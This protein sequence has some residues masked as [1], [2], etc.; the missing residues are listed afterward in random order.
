MKYPDAQQYTTPNQK[1]GRSEP[2]TKIV[3]HITD[4][5]GKL[6][7]A[8]EHFQKKENQLSAHFLIAPDGTVAQLVSIEN[9]AWHCKGLNNS[10]V[11]IETMAR[12]KGELSKTDQGMPMTEAQ[13]KSLS[14]L[15]RWLCS[16]LKMPMDREHII[17]HNEA[18][19]KEGNLLSS[20]KDC[21]TGCLNWDKLMSILK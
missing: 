14:E 21:P 8:I 19:D 13:Y 12:S 7:R 1:I 18:R 11:G 17:G 2:I 6:S 15:I 16:E 5:Q 4:G 3:L 20:H 10:T 9:T